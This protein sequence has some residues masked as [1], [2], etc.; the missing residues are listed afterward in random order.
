MRERIEEERKQLTKEEKEDL[1]KKTNGRCA[2]CG[3][4]LTVDTCTTDHAIPLDKGGTN[5]EF[6]LVPLCDDCNQNK[7]NLV[8]MP[9]E[10][11]KYLTP[12]EKTNLQNWYN[13]YCENTSWSSKKNLTREDKTIMHFAI[14]TRSMT[15]RMGKRPK[16]ATGVPVCMMHQKAVIKK[17]YYSDLDAIMRYVK[18]YHSKMGLEAEELKGTI[19]DN[20]QNGCIYMVT[21]ADEI[22]GV[23]PVCIVK[24]E[25]RG[26]QYYMPNF[27]GIPCLYQKPE[28]IS[29]M[30]E[31]IC[32]ITEG[33]AL[34]N[35]KKTVVFSI[36]F[37]ENDWIAEAILDELSSH[38]PVWCRKNDERDGD[39][40]GQA[41]VIHKY[42]YEPNYDEEKENPERAIRQVSDHIEKIMRLHPAPPRKPHRP[43]VRNKKKG[44]NNTTEKELKR[45]QRA[46]ID[47][48]DE[49]YYGIT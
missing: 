41:L 4:G 13:L 2:H 17:A 49:R 16:G 42:M 10:Y 22:I 23:L 34:S 24:K 36:S 25:F 9:L 44:I 35:K 47:E 30:A 8:M 1:L 7:A 20:F 32:Y 18:K 15:S 3:K 12:A 40:W 46:L 6:N 48:Y 11:F 43:A 19:T 38:G 45:A 39:G 37:P 21:K 27:C 29:L 33:I 14:M 31:C 28:Y 5:H 26:N